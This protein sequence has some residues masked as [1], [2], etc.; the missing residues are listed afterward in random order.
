MYSVNKIKVPTDVDDDDSREENTNAENNRDMR[1]KDETIHQSPS[2][3]A[4][5]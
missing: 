5:I 2:S 1:T 4:K 3:P